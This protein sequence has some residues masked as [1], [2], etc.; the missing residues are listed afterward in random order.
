MRHELETM[1]K[2][3]QERE[4]AYK[5]KAHSIYKK[6]EKYNAELEVKQ[7]NL[8]KEDDGIDDDEEEFE[9]EEVEDEEEFEDEEEVIDD[10]EDEKKP[11][12]SGQLTEDTHQQI[13]KT[14]QKKAPGAVYNTV[15]D[16]ES[17]TKHD[18]SDGIIIMSGTAY[19]GGT[20]I[21]GQRRG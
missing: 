12:A 11:V 14:L 21:P 2:Q 4:K 10:G 16:G 15:V 7:E 18:T 3:K 20:I 9:D 6:I 19:G 17:A 13:V 5:Q 8:P 1:E